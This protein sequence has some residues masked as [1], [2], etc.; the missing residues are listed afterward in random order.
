MYR[1]SLSDM[2]MQMQIHLLHNRGTKLWAG[3]LE[4]AYNKITYILKV[5]NVRN[6]PKDVFYALE[7][8]YKFKI[9]NL[10]CSY[11]SFFN[12]T[13]L[14]PWLVMLCFAVESLGSNSMRPAA[15]IP[16]PTVLDRVLKDIFQDG[17]YNSF[18][19]IVNP[20]CW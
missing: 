7:V 20:L 19:C 2:T 15:V 12:V 3:W 16:P 8:I 17:T 6:L 10:W 18:Y 13:I 4:A 1:S 5:N 11:L 9:H 14:I